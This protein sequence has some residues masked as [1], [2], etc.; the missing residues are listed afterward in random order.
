M[1]GN[2]AQRQW[3]PFAHRCGFPGHAEEPLRGSVGANI[4]LQEACY[5]SKVF[6]CMI[7]LAEACLSFQRSKKS[8][9]WVGGRKIKSSRDVLQSQNFLARYG[10]SGPNLP[11][12]AARCPV[13]PAAV[14]GSG[15][16]KGTGRSRG[17]GSDAE[18][19]ARF[20]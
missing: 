5:Y 13:V 17:H 8:Q 16:G 2:D 11:L 10:C 7:Y 14:P 9:N 20:L 3:H 15:N 6:G 19:C 18:R 1:C 12:A 4:S